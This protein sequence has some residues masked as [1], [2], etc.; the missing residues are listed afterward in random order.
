MAPMKPPT[1]CPVCRRLVCTDRAHRRGKGSA[2]QTSRERKRRAQ[3][4]ADHRLRYGDTCPGWLRPPHPAT[5][6]TADH[7][8]PFAVAGTETGQLQV[9]CRS[10]NSSKQDR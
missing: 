8:I 10:C 9:L 5:E 1:P 2:Y 7:V 6:L 4:V 3:V